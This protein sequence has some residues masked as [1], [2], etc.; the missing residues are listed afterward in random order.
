MVRQTPSRAR[1]AIAFGVIYLVWGSTYLAI[2]F[3][4]ETLPPFLLA[5]SRFALAGLLLGGWALLRGAS[6]PTWREVRGAATVGI[7]LMVTGNG[8]VTWAEKSVPSGISALIITTVPLWMIVLDRP[9][10]GGPGPTRASLVGLAPG[11]AGILVLS[12]AGETIVR[13]APDAEGS[14]GALPA[15][16]TAALLIASASWAIGSLYARR[17]Q[18]PR[19]VFLATGLEMFCG[20]L[21]LLLVGTMAG[22]WS[23]IHLDAVSLRS[24]LS[25][26]YLVVF[27]SIIGLTAYSWLL[28]ETSA[29]AVSTYAFVNPVVALLL[30]ALFA[31]EVITIRVLV[32]SLLIVGAVV[33]IRTGSPVKNSGLLANTECNP[34]PARAN[35]EVTT[36]AGRRRSVFQRRTG[37]RPR[38]REEF[39]RR[40][41]NPKTLSRIA[42]AARRHLGRAA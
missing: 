29:A 28:R 3:G 22:E 24:A 17:A 36:R 7:L 16:G 42:R 39:G 6:W 8:L 37:Q 19:S 12:G 13:N 41:W 33:I 26:G 5:G 34:S 21:A 27:G 18:L 23:R 32:A 14:S 31:G 4:V 15:L 1:L 20:G 25:W 11:F 35:R 40:F 30:G 2:R 38:A 9:F 10:F